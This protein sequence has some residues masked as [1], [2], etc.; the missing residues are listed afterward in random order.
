[1]Y[2]F[3]RKLFRLFKFRIIPEK[4]FIMYYF[5]K[6]FGKYPN[7]KDPTTFNEKIQW[8][9]CMIEEIYIQI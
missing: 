9:N 7:L 5:K 4:C 8:K 3:I 6:K 2:Q 1:M